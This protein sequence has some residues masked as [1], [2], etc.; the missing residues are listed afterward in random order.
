MSSGTALVLAHSV[1]QQGN[2]LGHAVACS[3]KL[4]SALG[5]SVL[6]GHRWHLLRQPVRVRMG[7]W[8]LQ[9]RLL[10]LFTCQLGRG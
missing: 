3:S 8:G 6:V 2:K 1:R 4:S 9:G 5:R 10:V 7:A